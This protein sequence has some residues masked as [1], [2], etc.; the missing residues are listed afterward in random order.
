MPGSEVYKLN[1]EGLVSSL[2]GR[3]KEKIE[4]KILYNIEV[5]QS[6]DSVYRE[7]E[8]VGRRFKS[9]NFHSCRYI[10]S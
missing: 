9:K 1:F 3:G 10:V 8:G 6:V 4:R 7:G 5:G 2:H